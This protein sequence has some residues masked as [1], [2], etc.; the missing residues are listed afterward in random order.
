MSAPLSSSSSEMNLKRMQVE[1]GG[2]FGKFQAPSNDTKVKKD[3]TFL[4]LVAGGMSAFVATTITCPLDVIKTRQQSS[5]QFTPATTSTSMTSTGVSGAHNMRRHL[6][7]SSIHRQHSPT[8][9]ATTAQP[10]FLQQLI[11]MWRNEG[12]RSLFKGLAP[13]LIGAVSSRALFFCTYEHAKSAMNENGFSAN[14]NAFL[15]HVIAASTGGVVSTT[16]TCPLWVIKLRQQLHKKYNK[17]SLTMVECCKRTWQK[18]RFRG[19]FRGLFVSYSGVAEMIVYFSLY[20][21]LRD[22]YMKQ[23]YGDSDNTNLRVAMDLPGLMVLSGFARCVSCAACYPAEVVRVRVREEMI[24]RKYCRMFQTLMTI[25]KNEGLNG[26][27]GGLS[28]QLTR[29]ALNM[30]ILM[31]VYEGIIYQYRKYDNV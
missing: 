28:A 7:T 30:A 15:C 8:W 2:K 31:G 14:H 13:S 10:T 17:N 26:L 3:P 1:N 4:R 18:E 9:A 25:A 6:T 23:R 27:Y 24:Q 16:V 21:K 20:E 29:Q 22:I 19:F 12:L 5:F 11:Y